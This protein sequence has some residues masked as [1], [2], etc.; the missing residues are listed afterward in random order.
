M[1]RYVFRFFN[2]KQLNLNSLGISFMMLAVHELVAM[3]ISSLSKTPLLISVVHFLCTTNL[4]LW[5]LIFSA[6][7]NAVER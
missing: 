1:F 6:S 5:S 7:N 4:H 2:H 3:M